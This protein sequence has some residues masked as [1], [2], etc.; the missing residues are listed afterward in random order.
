MSKS[1]VKSTKYSYLVKR[2]FPSDKKMGLQAEW[3]KAKQNT[4]TCIH[5][6]LP[7]FFS[8]CMVFYWFDIS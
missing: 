3:P 6:G 5:T 4:E 8:C 2:E 1:H 7:H